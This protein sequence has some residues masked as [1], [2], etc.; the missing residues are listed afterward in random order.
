MKYLFR[1][2]ILT[3]AIFSF[4]YFLE[5]KEEQQQWENF[6]THFYQSISISIERLDAMIE[7]QPE[8]EGLERSIAN[9]EREFY[10]TEKLLVHGHA[11][12]DGDIYYGFHLFTPFSSFL[13]GIK[14][15]SRGI[16]RLDLPPM[17]EDGQLDANEVALLITLRDILN[18]AR[19]AM[20]SHETGEENPDLS[21]EELNEIIKTTFDRDELEIYRDTFK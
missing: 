1:V 7:Q 17:A 19:E 18:E 4:L 2:V 16:V 3:L 10:T 9:L 8:G 20:Y 5:V 15:N 14:Y 11:Y 6:I 13:Y 12:L 21:V